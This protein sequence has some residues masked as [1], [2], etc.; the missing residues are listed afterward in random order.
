MRDL[1]TVGSGLTVGVMRQAEASVAALTAEFGV[2]RRAAP[3]LRRRGWVIRRGL[4]A[5]DVLGISLAFVGC[6]AVYGSSGHPDHVPADGE[7]IFFFLSLPLW[8]LLMKLHGLYERDEERADHSTVDD[9]TGV[10]HVVTL[11]SWLFLI[12]SVASGLADPDL[13]KLGTFWALAIGFVTTGRAAARALCRRS[14]SYLENTIIV[15]AGETGQLVAR[16]LLKHPE[17][18]LNLVGFV[19]GRPK[20]RREDLEHLTVLGPPERLREFIEL[21][22]VERVVVA[23]SNE[24]D[25]RTLALVRDLHDVDVQVDL[26]PRLFDLVGPKAE[27]HTVEGLPIIGL[28]PVRLSWSSR[29]LKRSLDVVVAAIALILTAPVFAFVAWRIKR[30]SPGP[31]FFRQRR[32]GLNMQEFTALK[33]RTMKV[34]TSETEHREYIRQVAGKTVATNAAGLFKLDRSDAVTR[35]G[36]WLR[37]TSLDEL[38]QLI[39]VLRGEMSLVGPRPC[40]GYEIQ[41]FAPHHFERFLVPAGIT[42]LWQVTAR[43]NSTFREALDMDVAYVRGWSLG[44]DVR[45]L[46]RTPFLLLRQRGATA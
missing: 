19:D 1:A 38:P 4:F 23:F 13:L 12:V 33:F 26:I 21:L 14:T 9:V 20:E 32:L 24:P 37:K 15:G 18:G 44:L 22:D 8:A 36:R 41:H 6:A 10:L 27:I 46:C 5:A 30:D 39:N 17:Y 35:T 25:A 28:P 40:I 3:R 45:L 2:R 43:A 7:V 16:K 11:G 29:L 34:D 31:I 42:G